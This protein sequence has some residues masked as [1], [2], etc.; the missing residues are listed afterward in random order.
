[1]ANELLGQPVI[2][3]WLILLNKVLKVAICEYLSFELKN[4]SQDTFKIIQ[5]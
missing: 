4:P 3:K 1:M 2:G 5:Q